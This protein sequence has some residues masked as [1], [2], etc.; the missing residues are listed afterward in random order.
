MGGEAGGNEMRWERG[1]GEERR[2]RGVRG[3]RMD[4][5]SGQGAKRSQT[6]YGRLGRKGFGWE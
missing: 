2:R 1:C 3:E 6:G 4:E 5:F